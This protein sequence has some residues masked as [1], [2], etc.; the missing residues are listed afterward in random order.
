MGAGKIQGNKTMITLK[1]AVIWLSGGI[2]FFIIAAGPL[3]WV[4]W[5]SNP[6][7]QD[8]YDSMFFTMAY[9]WLIV[10]ICFAL[11]G[12]TMEKIS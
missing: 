3:V 12:P 4:V 2:L 5:H 6:Y 1:T 8:E 10:C 11:A 9:I 7:D